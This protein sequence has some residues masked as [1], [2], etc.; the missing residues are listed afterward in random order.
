VEFWEGS[1]HA[2]LKQFL[3]EPHAEVA[4][5]HLSPDSIGRH[6]ASLMSKG[7]RIECAS[8]DIRIWKIFKD[9]NT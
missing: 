2:L 8:G 7:M 9:K 4:V 3:L 1:A 6:L 5:R